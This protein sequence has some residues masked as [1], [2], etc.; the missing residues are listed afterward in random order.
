MENFSGHRLQ[1]W[2]KLLRN[3]AVNL[4][5]RKLDF[6]LTSLQVMVV[7]LQGNV[8]RQCF[9]NKN[10]YI[11]LFLLPKVSSLILSEFRG[12]IAIIHTNLLAILRIFNSS[13]EGNI[14]RFK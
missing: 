6:E 7:L 14:G 8:A 4:Y 12:D 3:F 5:L 13:Q 2:S 1:M 10:K 11:F 9:G